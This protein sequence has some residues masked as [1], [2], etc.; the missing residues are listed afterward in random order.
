MQVCCLPNEFASNVVPGAVVLGD[1]LKAADW[2]KFFS[3]LHFMS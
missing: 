1:A 2:Q 3:A